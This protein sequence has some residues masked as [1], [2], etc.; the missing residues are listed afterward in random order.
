MPKKNIIK[1]YT[2]NKNAMKKRTFK[3]FLK[4]SAISSGVFVTALV[5]VFSILYFTREQVKF[6]KNKLAE[7]SS[8]IEFY[9]CQNKLIKQKNTF[10]SKYV[11]IENLPQHVKD[12][13][14][15]IEDKQF[16]THKGLNYKR[17]AKALMT[18]IKN[19]NLNQGASTISQQLIKNTHLSSKKTF[20]RKINEIILTKKLE[21][22]FSKNKILENYLNIIYF[23]NNCYGIEEASEFYFSKPAKNLNLQE[24]ATLAGLISSPAR[25]S[26]VTKPLE[27]TK[28]RNIVLNEMR[29]DKKIDYQQYATAVSLPLELNI[30]KTSENMLNTYAEA[31]LDEAISILKMPAKQISI[32]GYK[33]YTNMNEAKQIALEKIVSNTDFSNNN[34][35]AISINPQ[36]GQIESFVGKAD[37]KI[38]ECKR[39]PGSAIKPI[40]VYAPAINEDII[41]PCTQILDEPLTI[42]GYSPQN[43]DGK[44]HGYVSVNQAIGK[45]LNIPAVKVMTYTKLDKSKKYAENCG[46]EFDEKDDNYALALGGMTYGTNVKD[47]TGA[48]TSLANN[49][50]YCKPKFIRYITDSKGKIVYISDQKTKKVFRDDTAFLM[51]NMLV[52]ASKNG[53]SKRLK[54]LPFQVAS[55]TGTVGKGQINQD[56]WSISYTKDDIVGVWIGNLDNSPIGNIV[57]GTVPIEI[58]KQYMQ[59]LYQTSSPMPFSIPTSVEQVEIDMSELETNHQVCKANVFLPPKSKESFYFS[60]FNLP[61]NKDISLGHKATKLDG[62]LQGN[63]ATLSFVADNY[64]SYQLYCNDKL[65]KTFDGSNGLVEYKYTMPDKQSSFYLVTILKNWQTDEVFKEKSDT[66]SLINTKTQNT[67]WYI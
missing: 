48:Y 39:Q 4:I 62:S 16:Y 15:S 34:Y 19:H 50:E 66:I 65:I 23:G 61:K 56:A 18:D 32:G 36:N 30:S 2:H 41:S 58:T 59:D 40:L 20:S 54:D 28:R 45:S 38:L 13:F 1:I 5:L 64:K 51:T 25:Y 8:K 21:R 29:K 33:I 6:D 24:S 67:K 47:L 55:K 43:H 11:K 22:N 52:D 26:P 31:S 14:I 10:N 12:A 27:C 35:S 37:Y 17:M 63:I 7:Y 44:F 46:I 9:D 42:S 57:G 3:N 49:G 60:R 53:T